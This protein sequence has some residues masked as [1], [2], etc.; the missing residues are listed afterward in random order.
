M[1]PLAG[2]LQCTV[3]KVSSELGPVSLQLGI[4]EGLATEMQCQTREH[5]SCWQHPMQQIYAT[6]NGAQPPWC[7]L[8]R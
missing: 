2:A 5:W 6:D 8:A 4:V 1:Q 7:H 3:G